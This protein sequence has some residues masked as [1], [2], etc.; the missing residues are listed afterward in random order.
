MKP[1]FTD[2]HKYPH[3]YKRAVETDVRLTIERARKR[4]EL[5]KKAQAEAEASIPKLHARRVA[6]GS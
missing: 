1:K 3:G 5:A 6:N 2:S 4:I